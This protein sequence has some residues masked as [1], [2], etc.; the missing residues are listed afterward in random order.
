MLT[1]V[2]YAIALDYSHAG[3]PFNEP[4]IQSI[5]MNTLII[6]QSGRHTD[7]NTDIYREIQY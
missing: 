7:R 1:A 6:G 5:I 2:L 4:T 3:K